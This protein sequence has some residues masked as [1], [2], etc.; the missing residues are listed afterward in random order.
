MLFCFLARYFVVRD[1]GLVP[2]VN[3]LIIQQLIF[4]ISEYPVF[5]YMLNVKIVTKKE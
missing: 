4:G 1:M 3:K 5:S 2:R